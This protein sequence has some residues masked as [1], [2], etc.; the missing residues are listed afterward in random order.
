ERGDPRF[1]W[2]ESRLSRMARP[3]RM[4]RAWVPPAMLPT[5]FAKWLR[6]CHPQ[7]GLFCQS[8]SACNEAK[9]QAEACGFRLRLESASTRPIRGDRLLP[10]GYD[11][12]LVLRR[13]VAGLAHVPDQ[14]VGVGAAGDQRLAVLAEGNR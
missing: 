4:R 8:S 6:A 11:I 9:P 12:R 10:N 2:N 5:A 3:E 14:H 1:A 7:S 13:H